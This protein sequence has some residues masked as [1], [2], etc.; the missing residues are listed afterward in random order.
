MTETGDNWTVY[1]RDGTSTKFSNVTLWEVGT[2][3]IT[4]TGTEDG[5]TGTIEHTILL[6]DVRR[7]KKK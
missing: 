2:T 4:F 3:S 5:D 6:A 7:Y 1:Y